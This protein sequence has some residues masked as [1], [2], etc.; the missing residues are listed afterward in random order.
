MCFAPGPVVPELAFDIH[1]ALSSNPFEG[2]CR[3]DGLRA[4]TEA[5]AWPSQRR[6]F[7]PRH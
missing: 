1:R 4:L 6:R 3:R 5:G 7:P 2:T